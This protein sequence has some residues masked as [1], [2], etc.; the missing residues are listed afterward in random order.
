MQ[1]GGGGGKDPEEVITVRIFNLLLPN[2]FPFPLPWVDVNLA[3]HQVRRN[4]MNNPEVQQIMGDP[5]M[6]M[7]L[8][9]MQTDPQVRRGIITSSFVLQ[10]H[11]FKRRRDSWRKKRTSILFLFCP[12]KHPDWLLT[13]FRHLLHNWNFEWNW[14]YWEFFLL[15]KC[16]LMDSF[17][18][19]DG[20][21]WNWDVNLQPQVCDIVPVRSKLHPDLRFAGCARAPEEPRHHGEDHEVERCW[22][23]L[24]V[25]QIDFKSNEAEKFSFGVTYFG[26][27][28]AQ[29]NNDLRGRLLFWCRTV[30]V[31]EWV[32]SNNIWCIN[33][34]KVN[35]T[36]CD[37]S[38]KYLVK[39]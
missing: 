12:T 10:Y 26:I 24:H 38:S 4:A 8:E 29:T 22:P 36:T 20:I 3:S 19:R 39:W 14:I 2:S 1:S 16:T 9:Q 25:L 6:R 23:H 32:W 30:L 21:V 17:S 34:L 33:I 15:R 28:P 37:Y 13:T 31:S 5:A 35:V 7:I 11:S 27:K 18:S